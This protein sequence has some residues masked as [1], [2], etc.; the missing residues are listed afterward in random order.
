MRVKKT[1]DFHPFF[2]LRLQCG[3]DTGSPLNKPTARPCR[4]DGRPAPCAC[5]P[6]PYYN[7]VIVFSLVALGCGAAVDSI[8]AVVP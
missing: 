7:F 8:A 1:W 6:F 2:G 3:A 4:P 5:R